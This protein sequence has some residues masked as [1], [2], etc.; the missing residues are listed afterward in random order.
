[1]TICLTIA[2]S[3]SSGGAGIQADLKTFAA[4]GVYGMSVI[5]AIT[6]QNTLGV[7]AVHSVPANIVEQQLDAVLSDIP[8]V[9][10]KIGM[11][12]N[13]E[14]ITVISNRLSTFKSAPIV[15]DPV[16]VSSSGQ[17]LLE[18]KALNIM[19]EKLFPLATIITPNTIELKVLSN[20]IGLRCANIVDQS[21][22][23]E[24]SLTL[25]EK[26]TTMFGYCPAILS[27]GGHLQ[28]KANDLIVNGAQQVW[29]EG[30]RINNSNTHGTGC[31][32]S[33]AITANLA[34]GQKLLEA[35]ENAKL[36]LRTLINRQ[37]DLGQGVGP[38]DH[39]PE[40]LYNSLALTS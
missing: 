9:A 19:L 26:L 1:M 2:G 20:A 10:I 15:L 31:T 16:L 22:L 18:K 24:A 14:I 40:A 17:S 5:T 29:L 4:H 8:P 33:S 30:E 7:S 6:A 35:V 3:D 37:L 36:Y 38:L 13:A 11:L 39:T 25:V 28:G 23:M 12:S 34:M 27:K 21:Q 32:L